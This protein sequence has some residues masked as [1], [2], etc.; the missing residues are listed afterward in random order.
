MLRRAGALLL[1]L[2]VFIATAP[3]RAADPP[4]ILVDVASGEVLAE[5]QSGELW[6]PA[7]L[8][9]L[10]TIYLL[11]EALAE[12]RL[13]P[14]SPIAISEHSLDVQP[15]RMG[16]PAGTVVTVDN[17]LKMLIVK[18]A[19]DI[20]VAVAEM[21]S[22]NEAAFVDDM[23][24]A[25]ARIGMTSTRFTNPHGL[26]GPGQY[27]TARDLA[28]LARTIW[29]GFP[30]YRDLFGI[31]EIRYGTTVMPAG[32]SLLEFY[33]GATG[34]KTGYI[35]AAGYN[36]VATAARGGSELL[37]VVLGAANPID[38]AVLGAALFDAGFNA[39][40]AA[41]PSLSAFRPTSTVSTPTNL[42]STICPQGAGNGEEDPAVI[43]DQLI[44]ALGQPI[45]L[46]QPVAVFTGGANSSA[47][48]QVVIPHP[49]QRPADAPG[50]L[51]APAL[52]GVPLPRPRPQLPL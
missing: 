17:A 49:R 34:M 24:A 39:S 5:R 43:R 14:D 45:P 30:Q 36:L 18:S 11:F 47:R 6:F 41:G 19:N 38:R 52:A 31:A 23:N 26:P 29:L 8:A 32:N 15:S 25:A 35:C 51:P 50:A 44:A 12:G 22:V 13:Q 20:A 21:M 2:I 46:P 4:Y 10:M 27:S 40:R 48:L 3:A 7:S 9:K 28:L 33:P 37:A 42:R 1:L 16:F